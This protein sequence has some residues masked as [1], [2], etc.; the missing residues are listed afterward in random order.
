M[1]ILNI[2][3]LCN[4]NF[5]FDPNV[6]H[7]SVILLIDQLEKRVDIC[8]DCY[9]KRMSKIISNSLCHRRGCPNDAKTNSKYCIICDDD[10]LKADPT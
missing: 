1:K 7:L 3:P 6:D 5:G 8:H 9:E 10:I 2:C 4:S